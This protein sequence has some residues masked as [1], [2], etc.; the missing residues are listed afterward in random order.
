MALDFH[1]REN[2]TVNRACEELCTPYENL[3]PDDLRRRS[4]G[5]ARAGEW[6]QIQIII[7]TINVMHLNHPEH[8]PHVPA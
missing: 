7:S 1:R 6:L 3:T 4:A 8:I 5:D 2:P